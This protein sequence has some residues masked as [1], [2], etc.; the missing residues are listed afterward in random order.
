M[1]VRSDKRIISTYT[2][3]TRLGKQPAET[4]VQVSISISIHFSLILVPSNQ[5]NATTKPNQKTHRRARKW[6]FSWD[7]T[8]FFRYGVSWKAISWQGPRDVGDMKGKWH[9]GIE[10]QRHSHSQPLNIYQTVPYPPTYM[11]AQ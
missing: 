11:P 2:S 1:F 4:Q 9:V 7:W 10:D 5:R 8:T 3:F 6:I